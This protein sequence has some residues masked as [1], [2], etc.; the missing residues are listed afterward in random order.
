MSSLVTLTVERLE[1]FLFFLHA[2][3]ERRNNRYMGLRWALLQE[4]LCVFMSLTGGWSTHS[5]H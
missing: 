5:S 2:Q 1:D 3:E 4:H